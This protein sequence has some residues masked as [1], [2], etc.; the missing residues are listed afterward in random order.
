ML[1]IKSFDDWSGSRMGATDIEKIKG[2]G[3]YLNEQHFRAGQ[4][5]SQEEIQVGM[6]Q[7]ATQLGLLTP[8]M[9]EEDLLS[10]QEQLFTPTDNDKEVSLLADHYDS[11]LRESGYQDEEARAAYDKLALYRL[12][13]E[14]GTIA[15]EQLRPE[16][17]AMLDDRDLVN[18]AK[19]SARDRGEL[20]IAFV[21]NEDGQRRPIFGQNFN[22]ENVRSQV[23]VLL[24][25]GAITHAD[26]P[27]ID[28]LL[29]SPFGGANRGE[30]AREA[31][32]NTIMD[33]FRKE[34]PKLDAQVNNLAQDIRDAEERM[35]M[36]GGEKAFD[37]ISNVFS[38]TLAGIGETIG[39]VGRAAGLN[40]PS[41]LDGVQTTPN[42]QLLNNRAL[43]KAGFSEEE[44]AKFSK[45]YM[46][47]VAQPAY[48]AD[49]PETGIVVDS[50]GVPIIANA[51]AP[52]KELFQ[53]ALEKS[54]LNDA[55]K[56][57]AEAQRVAQLDALAPQYKKL[58]LANDY[59]GAVAYAKAKREGKSDAEFVEEWIGS[60]DEN[61]NWFSERAQMMGFTLLGLLTDIPAAVAVAFSP[62][63]SGVNKFASDILVGLQ[64]EK[65]E[66]TQYAQLMGDEYGLGTDITMAIPQ[67]VADIGATIG[68]TGG[69]IAIKTAIKGGT[70]GI[71]RAAIKNVMSQ[72]DDATAAGF[73]QALREGNEELMAPILR[74]MGEDLAVKLNTVETL[75]P[76]FTTSFA[77]SSSA[78]YGSL[79][80]QMPDDLSHE[81]K[82]QRA[83]K[84]SIITGL[85]TG[86]VTTTMSG[87]NLGGLEDLATKT[88]RPL[89]GAADDVA[90]KV[91]AL[92][93]LT[94]KQYKAALARSAPAL[95]E[96]TDE[97]AKRELRKVL[98]GAFKQFYR[99]SFR[100]ARDE[101]IEEAI[102]Q[103]ASIKIEEIATGKAT[104]IAEVGQQIFHAFVIGGALGGGAQVGTQTF[105]TPAEAE[106][107]QGQV[108]I[109]N[110]LVSK[111]GKLRETGSPETAAVFENMA[112]RIDNQIRGIES[113]AKARQQEVD[114]AAALSAEKTI[115]VVEDTEPMEMDAA[116]P[117]P[118]TPTVLVQ[119]AVGQRVHYAGY[120]GVLEANDRGELRIKLDNPEEGATHVSLSGNPYQSLRSSGI[121]FSKTV[122]V[123]K[124]DTGSFK[125]GTP[126]LRPMA[127]S[128][129]RHAIPTNPEIT[130]SFDIDSRK[131]VMIVK[132]APQIGNEGVRIDIFVRDSS[133]QR[134][135]ARR[136]GVQ[137][138]KAPAPTQEVKEP[139]LPF[140]L[141]EQEQ[142][143]LF[144]QGVQVTDESSEA[145]VRRDRI[146]AE[147]AR[148][149]REEAPSDAKDAT[150]ASLQ[151]ELQAL[152]QARMAEL[153]SAPR[154]PQQPAAAAPSQ[155]EL[156]LDLRGMTSGMVEGGDL[157]GD[158]AASQRMVQR[159]SIQNQIAEMER[160]MRLS[161]KPAASDPE[162]VA[163]WQAEQD[164][165][166]EQVGS[167]QGQLA[168]LE[169]AELEAQKATRPAP[170][171][172]EVDAASEAERRAPALL[173]PNATAKEIAAYLRAK[174][175]NYKFVGLIAKLRAAGGD[176]D[177]AAD[178]AQQ[179]SPATYKSF[180]DALRVAQAEAVEI[181]ADNGAI[182][183]NDIASLFTAEQYALQIAKAGMLLPTEPTPAAKTDA[184]KVAKAAKEKVEELNKKNKENAK[185]DVKGNETEADAQIK[186]DLG[187]L[188]A[189][190]SATITSPTTGEE[191][192]L[193][194]AKAYVA[195]L[196]DALRVTNEY[197][198]AAPEVVEQA[199]A[200]LRAWEKVITAAEGA[201][202]REQKIFQAELEDELSGKITPDERATPESSATPQEKPK[203]GESKKAKRKRMAALGPRI[204]IDGKLTPIDPAMLPQ[205][206][207]LARE[208]NTSM[209][210]A[211]FELV[212]Q[213]AKD[214]TTEDA[215]KESIA[216]AQAATQ[217]TKEEKAAAAVQKKLDA[218]R[219]EE[220]DKPIKQRGVKIGFRNNWEQEQFNG[221]V[222]DGYIVTNHPV[223]AQFYSKT[224]GEEGNKVWLSKSGPEYGGLAYQRF[225]RVEN[226]RLVRKKYPMVKIPKAVL[227][228]EPLYSNMKVPVMD[229]AGDSAVIQLPYVA[230]T[231]GSYLRGFYT[232]DPWITAAQIDYGMKVFVPKNMIESVTRNKTIE[233]NEETGEVKRVKLWPSHAGIAAKGDF[234]GVSEAN[235]NLTMTPNERLRNRMQAAFNFVPTKEESNLLSLLYQ[236]SGLV[237]DI[238]AP[239][240]VAPI[241]RPETTLEDEVEIAEQEEVAA[242]EEAEERPLASEVE[243]DE[244]PEADAAVAG[245]ELRIAKLKK[246]KGRSVDTR[247]VQNMLGFG[248]RR[249]PNAE[250]QERVVSNALIE[251]YNR[252]VLS[253]IARAVANTQTRA[254][255]LGWDETRMKKEVATTVARYFKG[256]KGKAT[257]LEA[258]QAVRE[259]KLDVASTG[260]TNEV[261]M[262]FGEYLVK[263]YKAGKYEVNLDTF[264]HETREQQKAAQQYYARR[265]KFSGNSLGDMFATASLSAMTQEQM[266]TLFEGMDG[267]LTLEEKVDIIVRSESEEALSDFEAAVAENEEVA[268]ELSSVLETVIGE[269]PAELG[270]ASKDLVDL[271]ISQLLHSDFEQRS[272]M[273]AA[274]KKTEAGKKLAGLLEAVG[275]TPAKLPAKLDTDTPTSQTQIPSVEG[276]LTSR[277]IATPVIRA[278]DAGLIAEELGMLDPTE[279]RL[280]ALIVQ[281]TKQQTQRSIER[282]ILAEDTSAMSEAELNQRFAEIENEERTRIE[283][284]AEETLSAVRRGLQL[285]DGL[286]KVDVTYQADP[287]RARDVSLSPADIKDL[288][289]LVQVFE[290]YDPSRSFF[291]TEGA[292][293]AA[294][295]AYATAP[296]PTFQ[297]REVVMGEAELDQLEQDL[298]RQKAYI[299]GRLGTPA[300]ARRAIQ[301]EVTQL[302]QDL[303]ETRERLDVLDSMLA[304]DYSPSPTV[305]NERKKVAEKLAELQARFKEASAIS[306][307]ITLT[308]ARR[309]QL[310]AQIDALDNAL[311]EVAMNRRR[312]ATGK[313]KIITTLGQKALRRRVNI[314]AKMNA[315][316]LFSVSETNGPT[317][318]EA[319]K[320]N[321]AEAARLGLQSGDTETVIEALRELSR[322]GTPNEKLV[323]NLLL[324]FTEVIRD[325]G[326]VMGKTGD[327]R[328]AGAFLRD[329]N[330][331]FLNLSGHDGVGLANVLMHELLHAVTYKSMGA[332]QS[333]AARA[334]LE[335]ITMLRRKAAAE[336]RARGIDIEADEQ[337]ASALSSNEEFLVAVLTDPEVQE[338]VKSVTP[339]GQRSLLRRVVEAVARFLQRMVGINKVDVSLEKALEE[340]VDFV[341]KFGGTNTYTVDARRT[342]R[343]SYPQQVQAVADFVELAQATNSL[344]DLVEGTDALLSTAST[345]YP[346]PA[347]VTLR[348]EPFSDVPVRF[349]YLKA[350]ELV[351]N[352]DLLEARV[353]GEEPAVRDAIIRGA[354]EKQ[355]ALSAAFHAIP[356]ADFEAAAVGMT[357]DTIRE[358]LFEQIK[359]PAETVESARKR[360][361]YNFS[362]KKYVP[363]KLLSTKIID[364]AGDIVS[365]VALDEDVRF[366]TENDA[367]RALLVR[368]LNEFAGRADLFIKADP[369]P[370]TAA[371]KS[372]ANRMAFMLTTDPRAIE[373][374][375]E[376]GQDLLDGLAG[377]GDP[378]RSDF[379]LPIHSNNAT[380]SERFLEKLKSKFYSMPAALRKVVN[381]RT[382]AI[383]KAQAQIRSARSLQKLMD[384]AIENGASMEDIRMLFGTTNPSVTNADRKAVRETLKA[385]EQKLKDAGFTGKELREQ[386]D[387]IEETEY[388][389]IVNKYKSDFV[390]AKEAA[391]IRLLSQGHTDFVE[392]ATEL[393]DSIDELIKLG[394]DEGG[395]IYLTRSYRFFTTEG[396][397]DMALTGGKMIV[398]GEEVDFD[399]LRE[400]A[401]KSYEDEARRYFESS[402]KPYTEEQVADRTK[403]MMDAYLS[404]LSELG[405]KHKTIGSG[406]ASA[407]RQ[408]LN[409]LKPKS[410]INDAML[411]LLGEHSDPLYNA[412][413]TMQ[414]VALIAAN[415]KFQQDF[416]K[417]ATALGLASTRRQGENW[418]QWRGPK[419]REAFG[420]MAGLYVDKNVAA[421]LTEVFGEDAEGPKTTITEGMEKANRF[422]TRASGIAVLSK[423]RYG[424]GYWFR[425]SGGGLLMSTA[426][427]IPVVSPR[428]FNAARR[429]AFGQLSGAEKRKEYLRL[430]ELGV[431]NNRSQSRIVQDMMNGIQTTSDMEMADIKAMLEEAR[432]TKEGD[433]SAKELSKKFGF[434]GA[435]FKKVRNVNDFLT[436]LDTAIENMYRINAYYY[437]KSVADKH[438][439]GD[440]ARSEEWKEQY[441]ADKVNRTFPGSSEM[442]DP[443][444]AFQKLP[445]A[446]AVVPFIGWKSEVFRTMV[447]TPALAISEI[448]EG[449]VMTRR[450][451]QRL[452]GFSAT[453]AFAPAI[454]GAIA[455]VVFRALAGGEEEERELTPME[456]WALR[457]AL[458]KW[459]QGHSLYAHK[460][461]DGSLRYIDMTYMLP[462]T[463]VTDPVNIIV[464]GLRTGKGVDGSRLAQYIASEW[465]GEQI[466]AGAVISAANNKDDFDRPIWLQSDPANVKLGK[467]VSH[468][469][470]QA[471]KPSAQIKFEQIIRSG[472]KRRV[473][474]TVGELLGVRPRFENL[475]VVMLRGMQRMK[476]D[477]DEVVREGGKLSSGKYK[478][479]D[480]TIRE[481]DKRQTGLDQ[482]R[483]DI[484][485]FMHV[486]YGLG[487]GVGD[488]FASG[489]Q[490]GFST[491]NLEAT[492]AGYSEVWTGPANP[493]YQEKLFGN[494]N[495][496]GEQE[497]T[498]RIGWM[499]EWMAEHAGYHHLD[500]Y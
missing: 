372:F 464:D 263:N 94:F 209:E 68:T 19:E 2:Y 139:D 241:A 154:Q 72:V 195:Q 40:I 380:K 70:R 124:Q 458:P 142:M 103:F 188:A 127:K 483:Q 453:L 414:N 391:R 9:A 32:F 403:R 89:T 83:L 279:Q 338:F 143:D 280:D 452:V 447:S 308:P 31:E 174:I 39:I 357:E 418:V 243:G 498:E 14:R 38:E 322:N 277:S 56:E 157:L 426:Q 321:T 240:A 197:A 364:V 220:L 407:I 245:E 37:T 382:F 145:M 236:R 373:M 342:L 192:T 299:S 334:A 303:S 11:I 21:T 286:A 186:E 225:M 235:A 479:R 361:D 265:G 463:Q 381:A 346:V 135:I 363:H 222:E 301:K 148:V 289:R 441:A 415:K 275:V 121:S 429:S 366:L 497:Y 131:P 320:G 371:R 65:S 304:G 165:A 107:I 99:N 66:L 383:N 88:L 17:F 261:L 413:N 495:R 337:L 52:N 271:A 144:P 172:A 478:D 200:E 163:A 406:S 25:Q 428:S 231:D 110:R 267:D 228:N 90:S 323:A 274:L 313:G 358:L 408:D 312:L 309:K 244:T 340:M 379:D 396:W 242:V 352:R 273:V 185:P 190:S 410:D 175:G 307:E 149:E 330:V 456:K 442:V 262:A 332:P 282:R 278:D 4:P 108:S 34:D 264:L 170:T 42:F 78:S 136:Y 67:V 462:H 7:K 266:D 62:A 493:R 77:R 440:R 491:K 297:A 305:R 106:I 451:I 412:L 114:N 74:E 182:D 45:N 417:M 416:T 300:E 18:Q 221:W 253:R 438:F 16:V 232:N 484:H 251:M 146:R 95:G 249:L 356:K 255:E 370:A 117:E 420:P 439:T 389:A 427:G 80:S 206:V 132:N 13:K 130:F 469:F 365:G 258:A 436:N 368:A 59:D 115:D 111:A 470:D 100:G 3:E 347:G 349:S 424:V 224:L 411:S 214:K 191:V 119:D 393:R 362:K 345:P 295:R 227:G 325:T 394:V 434:L 126:I 101:G 294:E 344:R 318:A 285:A 252:L 454:V 474:L 476:R 15:H 375:K 422:I 327:S 485:N 237:M 118:F 339:T 468:L 281:L 50:S 331:V 385:E 30:L 98:G 218:K 290:A 104:P 400:Q 189:E 390:S 215:L 500:K 239:E 54:D 86:I 378:R 125:K 226:A 177:I 467:I 449:G 465:F 329:S 211:Y 343:R 377:K 486:M 481:L 178:L 6:M 147:I 387:S 199:E 302:E 141:W 81:E 102:D 85:A 176:P 8:D 319:E 164:A 93:N 208:K 475:D 488:L 324:Q 398:N 435:A 482:T 134:Q 432:A 284:A 92:E 219:L 69:Y 41:A 268:A 437:E 293:A 395:D 315:G 257:T 1:D 169:Q 431:A 61:Y 402:G 348:E 122:Q 259:L 49:R 166:Q 196:W 444:K 161:E 473:D 250:A 112:R 29:T 24:K 173:A 376:L 384:K 333:A 421:A 33:G 369:L 113:N 202:R 156:G 238:K 22:S 314:L 151:T 212:D 159:Q 150:L 351:V 496:A 455:A 247:V 20:P 341:G 180:M 298:S 466:A 46:M 388:A 47:R 10:V 36:S 353:A 492:Y 446:L 450:G 386:L 457:Q 207:A 133:I 184:K 405:S 210:S 367:T 487:A 140:S 489:N 401:A 71:T 64:K 153:G 123:L 120:S 205:M 96:V 82:H 109:A 87:L 269:S 494:M 48:R 354:F 296:E 461:K 51:L 246:A 53:V 317:A 76:L 477:Y 128:K 260:S 160:Q 328:F 167:L 179:A 448:K 116:T 27:R 43:I 425:N 335:R 183:I 256:A 57:F 459:Q 234:S 187:T 292:L 26:L 430:I 471:Y 63:E 288:R 198:D 168:E 336:M 397:S 399:L 287:T 460:L 316:P 423:T 213:Q 84:F 499:N 248:F 326:F 129:V 229:G 443:V 223:Q 409:R 152:E 171:E 194:D 75:T 97:V 162:A 137:I 158:P 35:L 359:K 350:G 270:F 355:A 201:T 5:V 230:D 254:T 445:L 79:Y 480:T 60:K 404:K 181:A 28:Q 283:S 216:A 12:S 311:E 490:A 392:Q 217:M 233:I 44:I 58:I 291:A 276:E 433:T 203:R 55:Q 105:T 374:E 73:R 91:I 419:E 204:L 138:P 193:T 155:Q 272:S 306:K 23:D 310:R 472:E 360:V